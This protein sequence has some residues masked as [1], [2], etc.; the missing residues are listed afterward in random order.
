[1][2]VDQNSLRK[3]VE[4]QLLRM[5]GNAFQDCMDRLGLELYPGDYQPVRAAGPK[6]DTKNDGYCP[7]ARIFFAAHA[8]RGERIERTKAKIRGDL[9]GCFREHRDVKVWRFLTNDTLPGEI[10]QFI[11]NELRPRH[12]GVTIEVWGLKRLADVISKLSRVQVDRII[13]VVPVDD[14]PVLEVVVLKLITTGRD[15]WPILSGC[16]G[17]LPHEEPDHC[18]DEE[19][20]LIDGAIQSF[21]D[22][23]EISDDVEAIS[24]SSVRDA[25]RNITAILDELAEHKL[26]LY[27]AT[28]DNYPLTGG[29]SPF[30]GTVAIFRIAR[31]TGADDS[32]PNGPMQENAGS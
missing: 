29:P 4:G 5:E 12:P 32:P 17:W 22:W 11:D 6:G 19:Q 10:D 26:A 30:L 24:R 25:Q 31:L 28:T 3:I 9:E 1:M 21:R 8:T 14:E 18:T 7:K 13:D 23:S 16:L 2:I 20:D 15:L 27:A